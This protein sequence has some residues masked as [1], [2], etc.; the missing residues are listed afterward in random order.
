MTHKANGSVARRTRQ[1]EAAD[2]RTARD[3]RNEK[4]Q[5]AA[6]DKRLGK[7][8]GATRERAVLTKAVA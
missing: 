2:R 7:N 6:L 3:G 1:A 4:A 5:L 8:V